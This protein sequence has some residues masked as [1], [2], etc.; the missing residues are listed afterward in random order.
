MSSRGI[1]Y[2]KWDAFSSG[3]DEDNEGVQ[4]IDMEDEEERQARL[5]QYEAEDIEFQKKLSRL[6]A[7]DMIDQDIDL[8]DLAAA[9]AILRRQQEEER[10]EER[11]RE[12]LGLSPIEQDNDVPPSRIDEKTR[13][14]ADE[15]REAE[16]P[17]YTDASISSASIYTTMTVPSSLGST[18]TPDS[19][20]STS[21]AP[22]ERISLATLTHNGSDARD[23]GYLWSQ[24]R[25]EV[26][27]QVLVP[28]TTRSKQLNVRIESG[29]LIVTID[30]Q[31]G[32]I[33]SYIHLH[34][35]HS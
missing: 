17:S 5:K 24:T 12:R 8:D 25:E 14:V 13:T 15:I 29:S 32:P 35:H 10:R 1:D 21:S 3:M 9:R 31:V 27:I 4:D 2:S 33:S 7:Q 19:S 30:G 18:P 26:M 16:D 6:S 22:R 11:R 34:I 20:S 28:K 23:K